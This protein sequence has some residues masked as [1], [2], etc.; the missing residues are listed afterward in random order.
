MIERSG[1][2]CHAFYVVAHAGIF[3]ILVKTIFS[4]LQQTTA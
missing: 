4:L 2:A 3:S 1:H